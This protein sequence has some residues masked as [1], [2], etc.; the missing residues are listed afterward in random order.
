MN[1]EVYALEVFDDGF[2]PRLYAGGSFTNAG[3]PGRLSMIAR[4]TGIE[5]A[6]VGQVDEGNGGSVD[7]LAVYNDGTGPALYAGGQF[8]SIGRTPA[9]AIAKWDGASWSALGSGVTSFVQVMRAFDD[10]RGGGASLFVAGGI[11]SAGG[12]PVRGIAR[13]DGTSW[14]AVGEG[15]PGGNIFALEPFDDGGGAGRALYVGGNFF[16]PGSPANGV[17]R[18][19][20]VQWTGLGLGTNGLVQALSP[21]DDGTGLSLWAVGDFYT[22]GG[23]PSYRIAQWV[24]CPVCAA[25]FDENGRVDD[26]DFLSFL[27]AFSAGDPRADLSGD[28]SVNIQDFFGFLRAFSAG[29]P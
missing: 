21:H 12:V 19:D 13:W 22:A 27:V 18:W 8:F 23:L 3:G 28:G 11:S 9:H 6:P 14:S 16:T 26:Q 29:C 4:W 5:W 7:A 15:L 1:G 2:G 20:G 17:A 10:G 25:D 24:G